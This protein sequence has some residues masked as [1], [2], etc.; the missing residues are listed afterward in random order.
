MKKVAKWLMLCIV[1]SVLYY[2]VAGG[3]EAETQQQDAVAT[4]SAVAPAQTDVPDPAAVPTSVTTEDSSSKNAVSKKQYLK[5]VKK[6]VDGSI[7]DTEVIGNIT[8]KKKNLIIPVEITDEAIS[9]HSFQGMSPEEAKDLVA[10]LDVSGITDEVLKIDKKYDVL[11]KKITVDYGDVGKIVCTKDMIVQNA[12]SRYFSPEEVG[13]DDFQIKRPKTASAGTDEDI[14][15]K[16]ETSIIVSCSM[17]VKQFTQEY[18]VPLA[19]QLWTI[20]KVSDNDDAVMCV[21]RMRNKTSN[22]E[23][24]SI[25]ILTPIIEDGKMTGSTPHFVSVGSTVY[26]NDHQYDDLLNTMI[27]SLGITN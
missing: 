3:D 23:E 16:Y 5:L 25:I 12:V 18:D 26:G 24:P 6:A 20:V 17:L 27:S 2:A 7:N 4:S 21:A 9:G 14:V 19:P 8:L 13:L 15:Q 10:V 11:W 1:V 22:V